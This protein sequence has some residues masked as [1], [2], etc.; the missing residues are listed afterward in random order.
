MFKI[1]SL[2]IT[3]DNMQFKKS[4]P[5]RK[6]AFGISLWVQVSTER[7]S[8]TRIYFA[9]FLWGF[10]TAQEG[11]Y[12]LWVDQTWFEELPTVLPGSA[13]A[14][15][16]HYTSIWTSGHV[17]GINEHRGQWGIRNHEE[18]TIRTA[19]QSFNHVGCQ[20]LTRWVHLS[21]KQL[22]PLELG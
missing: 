18:S 7:E 12:A 1:K 9:I 3:H 13:L 20:V 10:C 15:N 4:G 2:F 16:I 19:V 21:M 5:H 14:R 8:E 17:K 22:D 11:T 6:G